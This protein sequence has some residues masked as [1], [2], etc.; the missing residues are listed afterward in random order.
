MDVPADAVIDGP[1]EGEPDDAVVSRPERMARIVHAEDPAQGVN[2]WLPQ[3][4]PV[5]SSAHDEADMHLDRPASGLEYGYLLG[6][7]FLPGPCLRRRGGRRRAEL[8]AVE[9]FCHSLGWA[10]KNG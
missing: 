4:R 7:L 10:D 5:S 2:G 9:P 6:E 8:P 1:M 3:R